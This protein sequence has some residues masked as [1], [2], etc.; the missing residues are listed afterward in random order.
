MKAM[1]YDAGEFTP[2]RTDRAGHA[3]PRR[4]RAST[5]GWLIRQSERRQVFQLRQIAVLAVV[6][7]PKATL[8]SRAYVCSNALLMPSFSTT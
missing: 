4:W 7:S 2:E 3:R 5:S 6:S 1:A 8:I